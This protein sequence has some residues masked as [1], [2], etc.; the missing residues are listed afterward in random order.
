MDTIERA[1]AAERAM[2]QE[3]DRAMVM[4]SVIYNSGER[5]PRQPIKRPAPNGKYY[6]MGNDPRLPEMPDRPTLFDFFK[7]RF[8]PA[9]HVMQSARLAQK[10]G[11]GEKIVLACLL[12]DIAVN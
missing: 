9:N 1:D 2:I 11:A 5:D 7:Y 12:H 8:G 6:V 4:K 10:N 3:L